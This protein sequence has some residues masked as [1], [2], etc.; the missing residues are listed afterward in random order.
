MVPFSWN[1]RYLREQYRTHF[2]YLK[3]VKD[4]SMRVLQFESAILVI[5]AQYRFHFH[6]NFY[7]VIHI[8]VSVSTYNKTYNS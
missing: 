3:F 7:F 1:K 2:F 8:N 4:A 6:D 5:T